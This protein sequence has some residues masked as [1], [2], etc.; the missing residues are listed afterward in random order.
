MRHFT[1]S[2]KESGM[3]TV[4]RLLVRALTAALFMGL[5][6]VTTLIVEHHVLFPH[7]VAD[8]DCAADWERLGVNFDS[9]FPLNQEP[10]GVASVID[11]LEPVHPGAKAVIDAEMPDASPEE[12]AVWHAELKR[13]SPD[14]IR[15]MLALHRRFSPP[16]EVPTPLDIQLSSGEAPCPL[17]PLEAGRARAARGSANALA[18]VDSAIEAVQSAEQIMLNHVTDELAELHRLREQLTTLRRLQSEFSGTTP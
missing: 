15:E 16:P 7:L 17:P 6:A 5:M 1:L 13:H 4:R 9:D 14:E 12:R 11:P 18:V 10:P 2:R 3:K 8:N